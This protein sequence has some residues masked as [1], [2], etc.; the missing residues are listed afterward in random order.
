MSKTSTFEAIPGIGP[1]LA[2][3]FQDLGFTD[4]SELRGQDP[5]TMYEDLRSLR[6]THVDRCVLYT[7]RCA[8]YFV[9]NDSHDPELL[10]WWS[11]K[12]RTL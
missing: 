4:A 11:W 8:V 10:K 1:K 6:G 9:S 5:E 2:R 7:F 3:V 12:D